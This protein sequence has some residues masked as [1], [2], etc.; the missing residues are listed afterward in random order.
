MSKPILPVILTSTDMKKKRVEAFFD[1]GSFFTIIR[2]DVVPSGRATLPYKKAKRL[3]TAGRRGG[4]IISGE[5]VLVIEI[6]KRMISSRAIISP[7][8]KREMIIGAGAMQEWDISVRNRNGKTKV[9]VGRDLRDPE[10][11]E[12]D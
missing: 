12:V 9:L 7:D 1:T 2:R 10:I 11:T 8:I 4:V 5:T 6:G 3:G